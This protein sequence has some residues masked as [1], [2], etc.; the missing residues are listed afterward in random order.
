MSA[1]DELDLTKAQWDLI[2]EWNVISRGGPE[3]DVCWGSHGCGLIRGHPGMCMCNCAWD[4]SP[5][6]APGPPLPAVPPYYGPDTQ[7]SGKD[8]ITRGLR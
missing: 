8:A 3:C 2:Q 6:F 4:G 5:R 7:F 1:W